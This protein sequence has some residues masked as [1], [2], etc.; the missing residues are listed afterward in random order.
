MSNVNN[1]IILSSAILAQLVDGGNESAADNSTVISTAK[2]FNASAGD[3]KLAS[4]EQDADGNFLFNLESGNTIK[5]SAGWA[6]AKLLSAAVFKDTDSKKAL[7]DNAANGQLVKKVHLKA[8]NLNAG[9]RIGEVVTTAQTAAQQL[10]ADIRGT[11]TG[12]IASLQDTIKAVVQNETLQADYLAIVEKGEP[13]EIDGLPV[14]YTA[15]VQAIGRERLQ[16]KLDQITAAFVGT[17]SEIALN[18]A[19]DLKTVE[20]QVSHWDSANV[21]EVTERLTKYGFSKVAFDADKT[22]VLAKL[23]AQIVTVTV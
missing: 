21:A 16:E 9:Q 3:Y 11:L 10:L 17:K 18:I 19:D 1:K 22:G 13:L 4:V 6:V 14:D 23:R 20:V 2:W 8:W 7:L 12:K 5:A 15:T